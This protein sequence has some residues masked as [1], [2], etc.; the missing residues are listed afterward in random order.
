MWIRS[1]RAFLL[2]SLALMAPVYCLAQSA[3]NKSSIFAKPGDKDDER[4]KGFR[5]TIE[6]LRIEKEK[7]DYDQM[8]ER[9]EEA[10]KLSEQLE[11]SFA[12]NGKLS[13]KEITKLATVEKIVKK[14]RNELGGDD[15]DESNDDPRAN[16][17][18][19]SPAEAIKS[20]RSTT[21]TLYDEL[22]KT[23]RFSISAAA[24]QSSNAVLKL[25]R[26]LRVSK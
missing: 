10:L 19:F 9:G 7:K 25:A 1:F 4:P 11:T 13:E 3:D 26:F 18:S 8:I 24:I 15:D 20:L 23:T 5:E 2:I 6:K 21:V 22:K 12:A 14:I 17:G 16:S